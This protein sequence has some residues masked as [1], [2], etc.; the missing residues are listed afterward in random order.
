MDSRKHVDL[1]FAYGA[2]H[3]NPARAIDPGLIIDAYEKDYVNFLCKQGYNSTTLKLVTGDNSTC[4][5]I[6]PGRGWDLN[7]P[8]MSLYLLDGQEINAAFTRTVTNVGKPS[9]YRATPCLPA[10]TIFNV[11]VEPS[12]LTFS[13]VGEKKTFTVKVTGPKISQQ[14]IM[15][16]AVVWAD[17]VHE[18]KIPL[19]VYNYIPGAPYELSR[20]QSPG[21]RNLRGGKLSFQDLS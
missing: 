11:V 9:T 12:T 4:K 3:L 16:G 2:G 18:V 6:T 8:S 10:S 20:D 15:S 5:G 13:S 1:E 19:V 21:S 14:P 17:D 7:Y